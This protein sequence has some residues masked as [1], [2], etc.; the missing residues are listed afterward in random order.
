MYLWRRFCS[1]LKFYRN[2]KNN[3]GYCL[4][5]FFK[6]LPENGCQNSA[7]LWLI[8]HNEENK[9]VK[10]IN[11]SIGVWKYRLPKER[12]SPSR[13]LYEKLCFVNV[14]TYYVGYFDNTG[15]TSN[16]LVSLYVFVGFI[17][18]FLSIVWNSKNSTCRACFL[19]LMTESFCHWKNIVLRPGFMRIFEFLI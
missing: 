8:A 11:V 18:C 19:L 5:K 12:E 16:V 9:Q 4:N 17:H 1:T 2:V 15:D 14:G 6:L 10:L 7:L 3:N 13:I